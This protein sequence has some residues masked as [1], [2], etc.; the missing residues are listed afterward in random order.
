MRTLGRH[1]RLV[2][3]LEYERKLRGVLS[4]VMRLARVLYWF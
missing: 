1:I 4:L 3:Q 2:Q